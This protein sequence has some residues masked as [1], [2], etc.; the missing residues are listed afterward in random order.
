[1]LLPIILMFF[2]HYL[3]MYLII[4]KIFMHISNN[5]PHFTE[6]IL[7]TC[8]THTMLMTQL[9]RDF[10][11]KWNDSKWLSHKAKDG[12]GVQSSVTHR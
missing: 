7:R 9:S 10:N 2:L 5:L 6:C 8:Q 3:P 12:V 11:I 4:L 1:M